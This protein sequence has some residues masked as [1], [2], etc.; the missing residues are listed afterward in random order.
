MRSTSKG[1]IAKVVTAAWMP[2]MAAKTAEDPKEGFRPVDSE[3]HAPSQ[4]I[5][6]QY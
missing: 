5:G 2:K 1:L 4:P 6:S 3:A